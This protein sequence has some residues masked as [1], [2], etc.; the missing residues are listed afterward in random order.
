MAACRK[1][2]EPPTIAGAVRLARLPRR[3]R[4]RVVA[5]IAA[6]K[7]DV[8]AVREIRAEGRKLFADR[9]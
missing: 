4:K 8:E 9:E 1:R 7:S 6:D 5:S 2:L 3:D